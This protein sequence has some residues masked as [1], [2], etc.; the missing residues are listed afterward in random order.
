[1]VSFRLEVLGNQPSPI[2]LIPM[3]D[4]GVTELNH[5][6]YDNYKS[7]PSEFKVGNF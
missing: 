7:S 4:E 5:M 3:C 6:D 2:K 1:M